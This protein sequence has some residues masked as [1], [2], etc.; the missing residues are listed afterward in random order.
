MSNAI[1]DARTQLYVALMAMTD[2]PWRIS[3][4]SPEQPTAPQVFIDSPSLLAGTSGVLTVNFPIVMVYDG[5]VRA[6]IDGLDDALARVWTA[7]NTVGTP[8]N[9]RPI[10]LDVGGP[11]LRGQVLDV[12]MFL[13]V[14]TLCSPS[15]M[16]ASSANG[17]P[18]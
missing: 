17:D 5:A 2:M 6:Q 12:Q 15:L 10:D 14:V 13:T 18:Q 7:A 9:S 1:A 16:T 4:T 8:T 11:S 3:R